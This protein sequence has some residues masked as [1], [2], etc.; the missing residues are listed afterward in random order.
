M[1]YIAGIWKAWEALQR[2]L[3]LSPVGNQLPAHWRI[4]ELLNHL[5]PYANMQKTTLKSI[6]FLFEKLGIM[7]LGHLWNPLDNTWKSFTEKMKHT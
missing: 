6:T 3:V 7:K 4:E 5:Q 1:H 2:H